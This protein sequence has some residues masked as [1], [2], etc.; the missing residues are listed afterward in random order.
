MNII[1]N[2]RQ[3]GGVTIVKISGQIVLGDE[4]AALG[5]SVGDMLTRVHGFAGISHAGSLGKIP[6]W[7]DACRPGQKN[8]NHAA[9]SGLLW[10]EQQKH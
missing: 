9:G 4:S 8:V 7:W 2:T 3:V 5:G 10:E 6:V 1:A